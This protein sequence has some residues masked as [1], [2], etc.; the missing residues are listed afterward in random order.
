MK[1][2]LIG[3]PGSGKG[4]RARLIS[5][6]IGIPHISM[7]EIC[8]SHVENGGKHADYVKECMEKG[9]LT[10]DEV[11]I[12]ILKERLVQDDCGNGFILDGF[13]RTIGQAEQMDEVDHILH[14][15]CDEEILFKRII[16]RLTCKDCGGIF[17]IYGPM[18]KEEGKCD[19][20]NGELMVRDDQK[21]HI[22]KERMK[23]Y[24]EQTEPLLD[25]YKDK[26]KKFD[27]AKKIDEA[28]EEIVDFL[29]KGPVV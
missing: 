11:T 8:R 20:C 22:I 26:V 25:F 15:D 13:P 14:I 7:G 3:G 28:A 24:K 23:V 29:K 17:N 2:V 18:P 10:K 4:S 21:E 6:E 9:I 12:E 1:I 5:E 27:A 16:G 19:H